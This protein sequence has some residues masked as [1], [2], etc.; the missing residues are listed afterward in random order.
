MRQTG[1]RML[2]WLRREP[3]LCISAVSA[4]LS[5][6]LTPPSAAYLNYVD[7]RVISLL[8]CLMAVSYTHLLCAHP[9]WSR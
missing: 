3:V 5:M 4:A 8:F 1:L 7:W 2:S 9:A 6:L